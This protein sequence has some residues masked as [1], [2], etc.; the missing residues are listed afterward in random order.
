MALKTIADLQQMKK[1]G[2]KIAAGV[3]YEANM[4]RMFERAGFK[5][6][7]KDAVHIFRRTWAMNLLRDGM[8]IN[9]VRILGGWESLDVLRYV[10]LLDSE[11]AL[12]A[13]QRRKGRGR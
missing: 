6:L 13:Y 7:L 9:D 10:A 5:G 8:Q 12:E 4:A 1:D 2:K 3:C 11:D